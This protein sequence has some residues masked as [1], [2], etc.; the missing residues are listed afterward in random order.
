MADTYDSKSYAARHEGSTP[1][2]GTK[3]WKP[4]SDKKVSTDLPKS[5]VFTPESLRKGSP[6]TFSGPTRPVKGQGLR[7]LRDSVVHVFLGDT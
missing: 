1:S 5:N 4:F 3:A 7:V 6:L 2:L